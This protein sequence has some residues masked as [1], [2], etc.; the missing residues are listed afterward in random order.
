VGDAVGSPLAEALKRLWAKHLT[1]MEKRVVTLQNA[2]E[3]L[4]NG[5]LTA[6]EQELAGADAHNLAGVLGTFGLKEGTEL[7]REAESLCG[8][9]PN[10]DP[11]AAS[12][13]RAIAEQL[14]S[15]IANRD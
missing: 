15:M 2:A 9:S 12:R 8:G 6:K 10:G 14:R 11:V 4:A 5:T 7:A 3:S 1:Q 13:L